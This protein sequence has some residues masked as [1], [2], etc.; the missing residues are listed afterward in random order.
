MGTS[1]Q[2]IL[3]TAREHYGLSHSQ[4]LSFTYGFDGIECGLPVSLDAYEAGKRLAEKV[5]RA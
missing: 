5:F 3:D 2:T 4:I 1:A